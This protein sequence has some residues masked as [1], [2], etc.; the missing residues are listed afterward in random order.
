MSPFLYPVVQKAPEPMMEGGQI[1]LFVKPVVTTGFSS[2]E[3]RLYKVDLSAYYTAFEVTILNET[4]YSVSID[5][6]QFIL[7][8][9]DR[10]NHPALSVKESL[11]YFRYGDDDRRDA[12]VLLSKPYKMMKNEMETIEK[13]HLHAQVVEAGRKTK[14][15]VFFKKISQEKCNDTHLLVQGLRVGQTGEEKGMTFHFSCQ[16]GGLESLGENHS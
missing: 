14:G 3:R 15:L 12:M 8:D 16:P 13:L 2:E 10:K 11:D 6:R 1:T 9:D 7:L 4:P 5:P